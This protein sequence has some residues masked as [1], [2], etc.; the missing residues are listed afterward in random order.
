MRRAARRDKNEPHLMRY[1]HRIG[2]IVFQLNDPGIPDLLVFWRGNVLLFEV[3]SMQGTLTDEQTKFFDVCPHSAFVVRSVSDIKNI[4]RSIMQKF[5]VGDKVK[6]VRCVPNLQIEKGSH[7]T[8]I[9]L[10]P[11][12]YAPQNSYYTVQFDTVHFGVIVSGS[13]LE[14]I[15]NVLQ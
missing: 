7:G 3:K 15:E 8:V 10:A 13:C 11:A 4:M 1:L 2:A 6:L 14:K 12:Y 5:S 9:A